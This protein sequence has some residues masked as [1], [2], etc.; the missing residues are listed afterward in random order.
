MALFYVVIPLYMY[1]IPLYTDV[2]NTFLLRFF[3]VFLKYK[4]RSNNVR[5]F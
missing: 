1:T 3:D 4:E 5:S 2:V